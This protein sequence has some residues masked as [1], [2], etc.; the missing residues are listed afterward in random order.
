MT[1]MNLTEKSVEN[2]TYMIEEIQK[3][4]RMVNVGAM[5]PES[6]DQEM[7]EELQDIYNMVMSKN[8]FSIS[9]MEALASELGT[10]R[11]K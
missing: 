10:L 11:K 7:Y 2:V 5:R 6:F 8:N 9:E 4:L 3:K 1:V